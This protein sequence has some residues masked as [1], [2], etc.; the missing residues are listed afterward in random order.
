MT[1]LRLLLAGT[2]GS[3]AYGLARPSSDHD[4][5]AVYAALT[6]TLVGLTCPDET[7]VETRP[8]RALH[9][10]R[11]FCAL[12]LDGNPTVQELLWLPDDLY[13][14][15][16]PLGAD[17]IGVREAFLTAPRVRAAY[18]GYAAGQLKRLT[19][20]TGPHVEPATR[21]RSAKHA[22]HLARLIGQGIKLYQTGHLQ[23]R[24][25]DPEWIRAF[26]GRVDEAQQLLAA[27][28]KVFDRTHTPLPD[29]PDD[30]P[31]R[32]WLAAVRIAHWEP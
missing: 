27:A 5:L 4:T 13:Q 3:V 10:A 31:V 21:R 30:G 15:R 9:E 14:T 7:T 12:A 23:V 6:R 17:L 11:K 26:G 22:R 8:G 2:V 19:G 29:Q 25:D 24:V 18:L 32:D 1:A 16:T 20:R 28:E